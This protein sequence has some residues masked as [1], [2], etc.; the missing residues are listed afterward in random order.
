MEKEN[1]EEGASVAEVAAAVA[2]IEAAADRV[3]DG[4]KVPTGKVLDDPATL[5]AA[6]GELSQRVEALAQGLDAVADILKRQGYQW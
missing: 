5:R 4:P 6:I 1:E 2:R 3:T